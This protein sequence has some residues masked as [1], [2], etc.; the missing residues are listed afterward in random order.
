MTAA[1]RKK[2]LSGI[3]SIAIFIMLYF[4]YEHI[5][6]IETD[7]AQIEAHWVMMAP[8][9][10][11][12]I[13]KVNV[14]EGQKVKHDDVLVEIDDR[15]YQSMLTQ[16]KSNLVSVEAKR[17]E[18]EKNYKRISQLYSQGAVTQQQFD[19]ANSSYSE[20][21]AKY[22]SLSAQMVQAELNLDNS[23]LK[24]PFDGFIS[25]KS[26]EVGQLAT[27]GVPLI[28]FVSSS[29]RWVNANVKETDLESIKVG[30]KVDIEVDGVSSKSFKGFVES[31][32]AATGSTFALLPPDN[33]TGNFTKVVQRVP[34][35]I[36]M[37]NLSDDSIALLK[38]GLSAVVKIHK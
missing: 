15:D 36:K 24:A 8:R 19:V 5:R 7:N 23:K 1:K 16:A 17:S 12:Y 3:G 32:S 38:V 37:E 30:A 21:K 35:K 6:Y 13:N 34:V 2:I 4:L 14:I 31:I 11:G 9:V 10:G 25:K 26:A 29:E 28:G 33:A 20:V 22:D 27:P 18:A